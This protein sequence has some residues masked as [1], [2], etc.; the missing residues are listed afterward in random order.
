MNNRNTAR[1][2][3]LDRF[4]FYFLTVLIPVGIVIDAA[5]PWLMRY[6][7]SGAQ[8]MVNREYRLL[9][10]PIMTAGV[11]AILILWELRR[12]M[13]TV[14][15]GDCFV[16]DNV[17]RLHHLGVYALIIFVIVLLRCL[18]FPTLTAVTITAVF[19]IAGLFSFVL[20]RVFR[21]AV[22]YKEDDDLTI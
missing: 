21:Q 22:S 1:G 2:R 6:L 4:V 5:L 14:V 17:Q 16:P 13:K 10:I 12:I 3:G 9:V 11:F 18:I 19:L 20:E 8:T 7:V 15:T